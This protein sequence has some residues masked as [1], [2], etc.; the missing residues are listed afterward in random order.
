MIDCV[1]KI[2]FDMIGEMVFSD[3]VLGVVET[4]S[5]LS[6]RVSDKIILREGQ[7][8]LSRNV[9]DFIFEITINPMFPDDISNDDDFKKRKKYVVYNSLKKGEKVILAKADGGQVYFIIDR[10]V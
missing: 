10:A 6:V 2:C 8:I 3:T 9:S 7:M 1:K 4:A 5:P